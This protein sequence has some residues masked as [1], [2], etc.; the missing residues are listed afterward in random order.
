M[1]FDDQLIFSSTY[2]SER[3]EHR[4]GLEYDLNSSRLEEIDNQLI[5]ELEGD[6][7]WYLESNLS[8]DYDYDQQIREANIQLNK[9]FHCRELKFSYDYLREEFTVQ[10]SIDLFPADPVGFTKTEDDLI[11]ESRIEDRLKSGDL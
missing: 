2:E 7:G 4:L 9:R 6:W 10:Y 11:F 8:I 5:Y 1:L 3:W